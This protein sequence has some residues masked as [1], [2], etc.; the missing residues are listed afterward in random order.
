MIPDLG[1]TCKIVTAN[2]WFVNHQREKYSQ[3][4]DGP[5]KR[6]K[7]LTYLAPGPPVDVH[8]RVVTGA[9]FRVGGLQGGRCSSRSG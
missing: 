8:L 9:G 5:L 7:K 1:L 4:Y 3:S 6:A 2:T